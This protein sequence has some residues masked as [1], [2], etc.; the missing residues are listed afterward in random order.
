[1]IDLTL[2]KATYYT[3]LGDRSLTLGGVCPASVKLC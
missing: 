3:P 1:M 2:M